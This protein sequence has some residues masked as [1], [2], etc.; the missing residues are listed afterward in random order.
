MHKLFTSCIRR[1]LVSRVCDWV[2]SALSAV[3]LIFS[4][5]FSLL[6]SHVDQPGIGRCRKFGSVSCTKRTVQENNFESRFH[7]KSFS[8]PP[9]STLLCSNLVKLADGKSAKSCVIYRTKKT[10]FRP[11]LILPLLRGSRAKS[12]RAS[13]NNV[14]KVLQISSQ[15]V[16]FR[17][18]YSRTR[19]HRQIAPKIE[20]NIRCKL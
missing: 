18:S 7:C 5:Q 20:P 19:K 15:S 10:K 3:L 8:P 9:W 6:F 14:L 11:P 2:M 4:F 1:C 16:H 12:A 13:P 17:R